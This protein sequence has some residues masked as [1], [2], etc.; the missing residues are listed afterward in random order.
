MSKPTNTTVLLTLIRHV[1]VWTSIKLADDLAGQQIAQRRDGIGHVT[2]RA[3]GSREVCNPR[4]GEA[5]L[6]EW[7]VF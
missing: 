3:L 7:S 4:V 6:I 2:L 5:L 1:A